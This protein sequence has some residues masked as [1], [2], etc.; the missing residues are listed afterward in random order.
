MGVVFQKGVVFSSK[1]LSKINELAK[2][3]WHSKEEKSGRQCS[4]FQRAFLE[5][6]M[7]KADVVH[8]PQI[9]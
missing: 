7:T 5:K 2:N 9:L 6:Q 1:G 3:T 8:P 4:S